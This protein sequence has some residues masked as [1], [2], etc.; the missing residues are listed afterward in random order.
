MR[1]STVLVLLPPLAT[2]YVSAYGLAQS[3]GFPRQPHAVPTASIVRQ[4]DSVD[5]VKG[6]NNP[7]VNC[8]NGAQ[9]A[10]D[11]ADANP[12]DTMSFLWIVGP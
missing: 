7:S 8:G 4:I 11:V 9:L 5:P 2:P 3:R 6:A 12:G 10:S 1:L